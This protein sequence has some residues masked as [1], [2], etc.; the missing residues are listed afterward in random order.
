MK[1]KSK[2][3][4]VAI[5]IAVIL[6]FGVPILINEC[7]KHGGYVTVWD[8]PDV[9]SY[10][11]TVLAAGVTIATLCG[12]IIF[13]RKQILRDSYLREEQEK[14]R[15][16]ETIFAESLNS[17]H[18]ISI[19]TA[20]MDNGLVDPTAAINLLQKYQISCRTTADKLNAYLNIADYPKVKDLHREMKKVSDRYFQISQEL[21]DGYT[22]LRLFTHKQTAQET[23]DIETRNPGRFPPE[24]VLFCRNVLRDTDPMRLEDIQNN[25]ANCRNKFVSE[26]ES[27]FRKLLQKKGATFEIINQQIQEQANAI[28]CFWRK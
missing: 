12:T 3:V 2:R 10:Y 26:Y 8:A 14:W 22:N 7:Y 24:T 20:T 15:K 18:P 1:F 13:T 17:I 5:V 21:V 23:L 9:L 19:L 16:I 4:L 6:I 28:L 11:G 27:S 25:I